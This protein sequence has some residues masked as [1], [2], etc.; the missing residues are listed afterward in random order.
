MDYLREYEQ[1]KDRRPVKV[2]AVA[3]VFLDRTGAKVGACF[4]L[5]GAVIVRHESNVYEREGDTP[6][7]HRMAV[8]AEAEFKEERAA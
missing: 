8:E 6:Y 5:A 4:L 7:F 2:K 1:H 3:A